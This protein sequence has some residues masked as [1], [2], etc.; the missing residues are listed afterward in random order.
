DPNLGLDYWKLRN[1]WSSGWGEDGYVRIQRGVNMCNV[2]SDAF[3][4]AKPAP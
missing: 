3:L 4:I 2:E 1:S